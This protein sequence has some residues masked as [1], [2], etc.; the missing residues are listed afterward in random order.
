MLVKTSGSLVTKRTRGRCGCGLEKYILNYRVSKQL[1][2]KRAFK[3]HM[4][5]KLKKKNRREE[6]NDKHLA[7]V[8]P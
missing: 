6:S 4:G 3:A 7:V 5:C 1:L 8:S 2:L